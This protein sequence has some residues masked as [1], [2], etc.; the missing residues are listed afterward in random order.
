M[1]LQIEHLPNLKVLNFYVPKVL[2]KKTLLLTP[3]SSDNPEFMRNIFDSFDGEHC[4]VTPEV[5]AFKYKNESEI[6]ELRALIMA[7]LEDF[8][9]APENLDNLQG[10]DDTFALAQ[11]V[12]DSFIRPTL[13]RDK[14][15]IELV[16]LTDGVLIVKFT[17]HCAGCPFAQNTLNNVI[18][19]AL[20]RLIPQIKEVRL[21]E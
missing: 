11:A 20:C 19:K 4:L 14:G 8:F 10:K 7:E 3:D 16:S 5:F 1:Q 15:D 9:E 12:A 6:D 2:S 18:V 21:E 17:G 13:N